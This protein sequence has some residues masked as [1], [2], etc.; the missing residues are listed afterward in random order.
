MQTSLISD[1][2]LI[3]MSLSVHMPTLYEGE[4]L[5]KSLED[6]VEGAKMI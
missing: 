3:Y 1:G 2:C 6:M 4:V 5:G